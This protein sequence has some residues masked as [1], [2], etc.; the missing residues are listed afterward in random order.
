MKKLKNRRKKLRRVVYALK[1]RL[2]KKRVKA[3]LAFMRS[4]LKFLKLKYNRVIKRLICDTQGQG[5]FY[6]TSK[7]IFRNETELAFMWKVVK[8]RKPFNGCTKKKR[9]RK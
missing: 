8:R 9:P 5:S 2:N 6:N 1:I 3:T 4:K 7:Y